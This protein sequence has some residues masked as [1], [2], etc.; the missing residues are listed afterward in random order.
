MMET[1]KKIKDDPDSGKDALYILQLMKIEKLLKQSIEECAD[2]MC[3]SED[4]EAEGY[5]QQIA[6]WKHDIKAMILVSTQKKS[7]MKKLIFITVPPIAYVVN[8]VM[9]TMSAIIN[10]IL[11]LLSAGVKQKLGKAS[12]VKFQ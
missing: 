3:P 5:L 12:L 8:Q 11:D 4:L 1:W 10:Q 9:L 6:K 7:G 2:Q